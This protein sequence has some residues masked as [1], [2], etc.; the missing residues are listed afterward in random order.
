[1][2]KTSLY[3]VAEMSKETFYT[4]TEKYKCTQAEFKFLSA[5]SYYLNCLVSSLFNT[6]H[7]THHKHNKTHQNS[8]GL[9]FQN[10]LLFDQNK[11]LLSQPVMFNC[12]WSRSLGQSSC[13]SPPCCF[14]CCLQTGIWWYQRLYSVP[15]WWL[16]KSS[17]VAAW[18]D[19]PQPMRPLSCAASLATCWWKLVAT[20]KD[21]Y[22]KA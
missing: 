8:L 5:D 10:H 19:F 13:E 7:L 2:S 4:L 22:S 1:M 20:A 15:V 17:V 16:L 18:A 9:S 14:P 11:P 3:C 12:S 21:S 6:L